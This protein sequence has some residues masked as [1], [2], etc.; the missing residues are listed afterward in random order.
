MKTLSKIISATLICLTTGLSNASAPSIA[1]PSHLTGNVAKL[2]LVGADPSTD[3]SMRAIKNC[4]DG[5]GMSLFEKAGLSLTENTNTEAIGFDGETIT[6][7][8]FDPMVNDTVSRLN[9]SNESQQL[10]YRLVRKL[11]YKDIL[12][13]VMRDNGSLV[14]LTSA[15]EDEYSLAGY[16]Y[17]YVP[18]KSVEIDLK[19]LGVRTI[20]TLYS[21]HNKII[22][23]T[24]QKKVCSPEFV[25]S[26]KVEAVQEVASLKNCTVKFISPVPFAAKATDLTCDGHKFVI[27]GASE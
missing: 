17:N 22:R 7:L 1:Y 3:L 26:A 9:V 2:F 19:S 18:G 15:F 24:E 13:N 27:L 20:I 25:E 23:A 10:F 8:V 14:P 12:V 11:H 21:L 5:G 16:K 6:D 4:Q